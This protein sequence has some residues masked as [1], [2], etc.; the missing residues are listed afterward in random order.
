MT[1]FVATAPLLALL[2]LC[3]RPN[4]DGSRVVWQ[5]AGLAVVAAAIRLQARCHGFALLAHSLQSHKEYRFIFVVIPLWL[6]IGAD[7][8]TRAVAWASARVRRRRGLRWGW[9]V[10]GAACLAVSVAGLLN[11]LPYQ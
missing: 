2:A 4:A 9:S 6:L 3:L 5:A 7:L 11:A 8:A 10:A 1:E